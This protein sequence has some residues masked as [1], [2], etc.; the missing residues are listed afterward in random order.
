MASRALWG[1]IG[2]FS[3]TAL[4]QA[5]TREEEEK[6]KRKMQ[7]LQQMQRDTS[8]YEY[9]RSMNEIDDQKT[10]VDYTTGKKKQYNKRGD[11]IA[12]SDV[13][14]SDMDL[15]KRKLAKDDLENQNINSQIQ[16]RAADDA[17]GN[18]SLGI[19]QAQ[20][21]MERQRI[22]LEQQRFDYAKA[23]PSG[24][25]GGLDGGKPDEYAVGRELMDSYK[26]LVN[27]AVKSGVDRGELT[28][29]AADA[30]K[31]ALAAGSGAKGAQA[32]FLDELRRMREL[33][34]NKAAGS[35]KIPL[36]FR[37]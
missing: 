31:T 9:N 34:K 22:G 33:A 25:S 28:Q 1:F 24:G 2:G 27:E 20:L 5:K 16:S 11:L 35:T 30:A 29:R 15:Y 37:N 19:Q 10:E 21:G 3:K 26:D 17:R 36:D 4:D 7:L 18:A 6:E 23:H 13:S 32:I 14:A 12:T 8:D